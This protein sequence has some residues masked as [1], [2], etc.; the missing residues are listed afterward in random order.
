MLHSYIRVY[1]HYT[2]ATK[3]RQRILTDKVRPQLR[4]HL[5][6]YAAENSITIDSINVQVEHV[7]TLIE[8]K[9]NQ[10]ID[11]PIKLIKG[12][13]SHWMNEQDIIPCKFS[14]QRGYGAFSV[15]YSQID[16]VRDYIARQDEHHRHKSFL[17]EY[18]NFIEEYGLQYIDDTIQ[19]DT[20]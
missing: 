12:E 6:H 4:N 8:L 14:W 13:S 10:S 2:W 15:G 11:Y 16:M 19:E 18:T 5:I 9:S 3:H 17:E 1:I 20:P 7:H